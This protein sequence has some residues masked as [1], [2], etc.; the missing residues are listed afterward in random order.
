MSSSEEIPSY[1]WDACVFLAYV[2]GE[3]DRVPD[4]EGLLEAARRHECEIVTSTLTIVEVS[5]GV[6]QLTGKREHAA[7]MR[8]DGLWSTSSPINLI[9]FSRSVAEAARDYKRRAVD[10]GRAL[11]TMDA[12]HLASAVELQVDALHT[13]DTKLGGWADEVPIKI[14]EPRGSDRP[15]SL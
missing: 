7:E 6:T 11:S 15:M 3:E 10:L 5:S 14:E 4:I 12:I 13:Y 2:K 1:Y 8:I 9:E